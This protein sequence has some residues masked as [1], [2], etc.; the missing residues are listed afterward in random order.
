MKN[1]LT[2][3][4][5]SL[6]GCSVGSKAW[7]SGFDSQLVCARL[8]R[9]K[10]PETP[11]VVSRADR[12]LQ[13]V[14]LLNMSST[15]TFYSRRQ[16]SSSHRQVVLQ[17]PSAVVVTPALLHTCSPVQATLSH[18]THVSNCLRAWT[19][20]HW[21]PDPGERPPQHTTGKHFNLVSTV[22]HGI[23]HEA[24]GLQAFSYKDP[25][26][27]RQTGTPKTDSILIRSI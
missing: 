10:K 7:R 17:S 27:F 19:A 13:L 18:S 8:M 5:D 21:C 25:G 3:T 11:V 15:R 16:L 23:Q 24:V 20:R 12:C 4:V 1:S 2:T 14:R 6:D 22:A 9:A 26:L